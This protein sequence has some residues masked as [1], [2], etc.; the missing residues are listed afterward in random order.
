M[1]GIATSVFKKL[2]I[3]RQPGLGSL[4]VPGPA[5]SAKSVRRVT[6]T[7]DLT[8]A[9]FGSAE[10]IESQQRRDNRHG[11][12]STGGTLSGEL[13]VG[14][15]QELFESVLRQP[16][17]QAATSG[18]VNNVV[19]VSTGERTGAI[20]RP[21]GNWLTDG[22]KIGDIVSVSGY[23]GVA[24]A[25]NNRY[26]MIVGLT[27]G[28]MTLLTLNASPMVA[29]AA[30]DPLTV[31]VVGRKTWI[32]ASGHS[33]DY[34][35]VEHWFGD[36]G[37]SEVFRDTVVTGFTVSLPPTGMAT[38]EFPMMGLNMTPGKAQ[39]FTT[40]AAPSKGAN[41]AAANGALIING[42]LA[43]LVTGMTI[44]A[45]GNYAY[46]TG[47]GIV[48][49]NERPDVLPG[50][51]DVTGQLTVLFTNGYFRDL[52][53]NEEEATIAM[54]M[55]TDNKPAPGFAAFVMSRVKFSGSSKDDA[56]TGLTLTM[57]YTAL[58]NINPD[59]GT[60]LPNLQ[61]TISVQD[62]AFTS[63]VGV[64]DPG[65]SP[66]AVILAAPNGFAWDFALHPITVTRQVNG[67]V[68][69]NLDPKSKVNAT[70][71]SGPAYY[72][73]QGA[74][75]TGDGLTE[76]TAVGSMAV[77]LKKLNDNAGTT[78]GRMIVKGD[79]FDMSSSIND[80][81]N[82][83]GLTG[84]RPA[85]HVGVIGVL[86]SGGKKPVFGPVRLGLAFTASG[87][88]SWNVVRSLTARV[89]DLLSVDANGDYA[90]IPLRADAATVE[91]SNGYYQ[92]P[93]T[94][95]TNANV[96][97]IKRQDGAK[98]DDTNTRVLL[99]SDA[100]HVGTGNFDVY[101]ENM[102]IQGGQHGLRAIGGTRN[103]VCV[104]TVSKY[105]GGPAAPGGSA[106]NM[107]SLGAGSFVG[108]FRC[109][110]ARAAQDGFTTT[111]DFYSLTVDCKG[112]DN[113]MAGSTSNNGLTQHLTMR[114]IDLGGE[115]Y[116]NAGG[117]V[118]NIDD[119]IIWAPNTYAHDDRGDVIFGG[120]LAPCDFNLGGRAKA[121]FD[122]IRAA[123]SQISLATDSST[124]VNLKA[125]TLPNQKIVNGTTNNYT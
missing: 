7:L 97:K 87:N 80:P 86:G 96:L 68:T 77:A 12:K 71:F 82:T 38:V 89:L 122:T 57:P 85:K 103:I 118:R 17:Q 33:R 48:G 93:S 64:V 49:S 98:P 65:P 66:E 22:F 13:S 23:T 84:I 9:S 106:F 3:K 16:T 50:V 95:A 36:V 109:V 40:P 4:A 120:S 11:V 63:A 78:G 94:D 81:G 51:L 70:I 124:I 42:Q 59:A 19:T 102:E 117:N 34:Y 107:A 67:T 44:V 123:G 52:F 88:G 21:T 62:S 8:K 30:S 39:Y 1:P 53:I 25:N 47:D 6:S 43:G 115:Y 15:Y 91:A 58:E 104:D 56:A 20:T 54:V 73:T 24:T 79:L 32:P 35:T 101:M 83:N 55:T 92:Y 2:F 105:A 27:G 46:P 5:G 41:L 10:V 31:A 110:A 37:E 14:T 114:G 76:A 116:R 29:K 121:W 90:E 18:A 26:C 60:G 113:G 69:T 74:T 119:T 125:A 99:S 28:T 111:G 72:V 75:N 108:Y 100:F 112:R 45:N 61:T